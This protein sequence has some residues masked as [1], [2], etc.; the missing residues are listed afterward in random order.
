MSAVKEVCCSGTT[1]PQKFIAILKKKQENDCSFALN[2]SIPLKTRR[3]SAA[4]RQLFEG[5]LIKTS[6]LQPSGNN[7]LP[8]CSARER[9]KTRQFLTPGPYP[10]QPWEV[11]FFFFFN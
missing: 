4:P 5:G 3:I 6:S 8:L 9:G 10:S 2:P 7:L 11:F 1:L